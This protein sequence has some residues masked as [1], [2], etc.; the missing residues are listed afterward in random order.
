METDFL[1]TEM[2][3]RL[4]RLRDADFRFHVAGVRELRVRNLLHLFRRRGAMPPL[5]SLVGSVGGAAAVALKSAL[6]MG[7]RGNISRRKP[8]SIALRGHGSRTQARTPCPQHLHE[9]RGSINGFRTS[10][11][12]DVVVLKQSRFCN[13]Q[14]AHDV[15]VGGLLAVP[16]AMMDIALHEPRLDESAGNHNR[17][18]DLHRLAIGDRPVL[19]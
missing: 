7:I 13:S 8:R 15:R 11:A 17:S 1:R 14:A 9:L 5:Q 4:R 10:P 12:G 3:G 16:G 6:R 19:R 18:P 2:G